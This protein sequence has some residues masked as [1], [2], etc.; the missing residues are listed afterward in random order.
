MSDTGRQSMTDKAA[1]TMKPDSQ[2]SMTEHA[3]DKVKGVSD[4]VASTLQ[5]QSEK[6]TTQKAGDTLSGNSNE[7]QESLTDKAKHVMGLGGAE[8]K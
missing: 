2:K 1:S 3:G 7:D 5:P 6:S 8:R 4:S